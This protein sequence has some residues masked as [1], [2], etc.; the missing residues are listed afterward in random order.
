LRAKNAST[1]WL[2]SPDSAM[3]RAS[4]S[5]FSR[6]GLVATTMVDA[7]CRDALESAEGVAVSAFRFAGRRLER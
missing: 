4:R 5:H 6:I 7:G 1:C 3:R 2:G